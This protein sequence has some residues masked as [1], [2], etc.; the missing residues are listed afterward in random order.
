MNGSWEFYL[1]P[2]TSQ[3]YRCWWSRHQVD[4]LSSVVS[5]LSPKTSRGAPTGEISSQPGTIRLCTDLTTT[6]VSHCYPHCPS[7]LFYDHSDAISASPLSRLMSC[8]LSNL[9]S[10]YN[11]DSQGW[12]EGL[13][14]K[15][16]HSNL[17]WENPYS[18]PSALTVCHKILIFPHFPLIFVFHSLLPRSPLPSQVT[19]FVSLSPALTNLTLMNW[20]R[21]SFGGGLL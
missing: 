1:V 6:I 20:S 12:P 5:A 8:I 13:P 16:L 3:W 9:I 14:N 2:E 17:H 15:A 4:P 11:N 7:L 10:Q 21:M 19:A 18:P